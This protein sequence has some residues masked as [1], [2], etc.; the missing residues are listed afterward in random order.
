MAVILVS[1]R[2]FG[3]SKVQKRLA[4]LPNRVSRLKIRLAFGCLSFAVFWRMSHGS[5]SLRP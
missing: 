5:E 2:A 3:N 1:G 4:R